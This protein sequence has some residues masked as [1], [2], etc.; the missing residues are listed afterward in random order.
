MSITATIAGLE[1]AGKLMRYIPPGNRA[2]SRR[3]FLTEQAVKDLTSPSSA[4]VMLIGRGPLEAALARWC[5]K[6]RIVGNKRRGTFID[7]LCSPPS[8]IWEMRVTEANV[9]A[10]LFGRFAEP[11]TLILTAFHTRRLLGNKGSTEWRNAMR[12]CEATWNSLF[13]STQPFS[14]STIKAYVTENCDDFP[15]CP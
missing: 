8:E 3:L 12:R 15:L 2:P 14:A 5:L 6:Q 10:R 4:T 7:R 9:Q 13:G 11:D 1:A